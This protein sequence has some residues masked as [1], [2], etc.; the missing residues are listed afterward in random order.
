MLPP[1]QWP[2]LF[3]AVV[4]CPL[5]CWVILVAVS[6]PVGQAIQNCDMVHIAMSYNKSPELART[7]TQRLLGAGM[8]PMVSSPNGVETLQ[9]ILHKLG[10]DGL[11]MPPRVPPGNHHPTFDPYPAAS[12][13]N[14]NGQL[15]GT[16]NG[17]YPNGQLPGTPNCNQETMV[18]IR[19]V[20]M[21]TMAQAVL[22]R[23][24]TS[25]RS[26]DTANATDRAIRCNWN[27]GT[28]RLSNTSQ[29]LSAEAQAKT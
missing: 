1:C 11:W 7:K 14:L 23:E 26:T 21:F 8:E 4:V 29:M 16:P 25:R 13:P 27:V 9:H 3:A 2:H 17:Y 19:V 15:P 10:P 5:D 6:R 20:I 24:H 28:L 12:S 22:A 18:K